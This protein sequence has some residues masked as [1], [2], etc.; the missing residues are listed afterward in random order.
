MEFLIG[1]WLALAIVAGYVGS[2]RKIGFF[3]AFLWSILLSPLI[4]LIIA[5]ASDKPIQVKYVNPE[6][7]KLRNEGDKL[8]KHQRYDEAI[9]KYK[10]ILKYSDDAPQTQIKLAKL[11]SLKNDGINS[12]KHLVLALQSGYKDFAIIQ[13]DKDF[14]FLRGLNEFQQLVD[15]NYK[16]KTIQN[17]PIKF[18]NNIEELERLT[19]L[20]ERGA[21]TKEEF[22][23]MKKNILI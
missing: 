14:T 8:F 11:Y 7:L 5:F 15:N 20:F 22:E 12:F 18:F 21:L 6:L 10:M 9:E 23:N 17:Q 3:L 2:K 16:L 13:N 4:G 1:G 19:G